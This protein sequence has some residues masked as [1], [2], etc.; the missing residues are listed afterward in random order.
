MIRSYLS[1]LEL[2]YQVFDRH[3][4]ELLDKMLVLDPSQ[5]LEIFI[6]I[7]S[8]YFKTPFRPVLDIEVIFVL[9]CPGVENNCK[10]CS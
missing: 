1:F 10:G 6:L 5:V 7:G 2:R 9:F 3:A 8:E 4:L